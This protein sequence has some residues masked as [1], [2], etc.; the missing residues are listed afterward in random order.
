MN[1]FNITVNDY[2]IFLIILVTF[3]TS[4]LLTPIVKKIALHVG[5]LDI[6]DNNRKVHKRV[7]PRLGGLAMF[8]AFLYG[9]I[10]FAP[11]TTQMLSVLIGAFILIIVGIV[12]DIKPLPVLPKLIGQILAASIVVLY[13]HF[14]I[15]IIQIFGR[16]LEFGIFSYPLAIF[17]IVAIINSINF[18]DGLDGLAAGTSTIYF[19]AV[20]VLA[21]IMNRLGG[22]DVIL[23]L[24][25]IGACLGF[26]VFNYP[27]A[28]IFMGDTGSMF[29]GFII[30]IIS[31]L[32]FKTATITSLIIPL[33]LLFVPILDTALAMLRRT[34]KGESIGKADR[35]HLHHQL[36]KRTESTKHSVLIMYTINVLFAIVSVLY[37]I[38][39]KKKSMI[40]Y[41][42]L[43][44]LFVILVL[45]T[46]ILFER[47]LDDEDETLIENKDENIKPEKKESS[48][49]NTTKNTK[50]KTTKKK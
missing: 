1:I 36:L 12:D 9:Y 8:F 34:L 7:M 47:V 35:Q 48:K 17:F 5:A 10:L 14:T 22:L 33:L 13:G 39:D 38:G 37:T 11:K 15:D 41:I 2:N 44:L 6:P 3:V 30:S 50:K 29:L 28:S 40:V 27:P 21:Y 43:L 20:A 31:L 45:K 32:G 4:L 19:I 46:D 42:V 25:M 49:K 18:A 26:L 23:C 24:I 16:T